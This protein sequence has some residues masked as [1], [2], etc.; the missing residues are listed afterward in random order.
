MCKEISICFLATISPNQCEPEKQFRCEKSGICIP[1]SWY[2]DGTSDCDD[3]SDE[4]KSCGEVCYKC[5]FRFNKY[6][7][8]YIYLYTPKKRP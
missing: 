3:D 1:K 4:P 5:I 6:V 8:V 7:C 2:C